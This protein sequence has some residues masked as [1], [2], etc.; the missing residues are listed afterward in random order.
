MAGRRD[1]RIGR[2]HSSAPRGDGRVG[3]EGKVTR[4]DA[5]VLPSGR[6]REILRACFPFAAPAW[7]LSPPRCSS[8]RA[9]RP[10]RRRRSR[11]SRW[12]ACARPS[13]R[14]ALVLLIPAA[15]R[16]YTWRAAA[17]GL[18]FA[19][20]LVLFVTA[21]KL[22][23]SAASIFLQSTAPLYV[24]L[25]RPWLLRE[26]ASRSDLAHH[27][28]G[29][30]G[31]PPR[32]RRDRNGGADRARSLPR[33]RARAPLRR[34]LGVRHHGAALDVRGTRTLAPGRGRARKRLRGGRLPAL[35]PLVPRS[36]RP[37]TGRRSP[38]WGL[39]GGGRL[40]LPHPRGGEAPGP[41]RVAAPARGAGAQP[42]LGLDRARGASVGAGARR[43]GASSSARRR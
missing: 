39:P 2:Q 23:T 38:T 35:P 9:A 16:G 1:H 27:A 19:G 14:V 10:S 34:D 7:R 26:R 41:R 24:L 28:P 5:G 13:P 17:V 36:S 40:R 22:T 3:A 21:N 20:S 30:G 12:E 31:A 43:R 32:V 25:A 18:A 33:E 42:G 8:P 11:A 15:R 4:P 6:S 37:A 29:G